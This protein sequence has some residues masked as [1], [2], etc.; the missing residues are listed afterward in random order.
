MSIMCTM[1]THE[2]NRTKGGTLPLTHTSSENAFRPSAEL[3]R[4]GPD[5]NTDRSGVAE[6]TR[7]I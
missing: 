2:Y 5:N 4:R 1:L 7:A 3:E 6:R